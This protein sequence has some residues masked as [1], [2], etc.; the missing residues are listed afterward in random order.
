MMKKYFK[1]TLTKDACFTLPI[2]FS[3]KKVFIDANGY[4]W[5]FIQG[6]ELT[7][8]SGYSWDGCTPKVKIKL[9]FINKYTVVGAWDGFYIHHPQDNPNGGSLAGQELKYPSLKHDVL[10]QFFK[11]LPKPLDKTMIDQWFL[12]D[13]NKVGFIFAKLYHA[14]VKQWGR[15]DG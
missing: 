14:A 7:V 2:R 8:L 10:C 6:N 3:K 5:A 15:Y 12:N 11:Q 4:M 9:P 13:C 1:Y